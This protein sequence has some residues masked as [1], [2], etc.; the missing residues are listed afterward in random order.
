MSGTAFTDSIG[1]LEN[2]MTLYELKQRPTTLQAL[3][4]LRSR[5]CHDARDSVYGA[6]GLANQTQLMQIRP[7]YH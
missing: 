5:G 7:G 1:I 2:P 6:L 4:R 3:A